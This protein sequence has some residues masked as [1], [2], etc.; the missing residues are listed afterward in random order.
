MRI[1]VATETSGWWNDGPYQAGSVW[2]AR[3]RRRVS[4]CPR[5]TLN[6]HANSSGLRKDD[7]IICRDDNRLGGFIS[8]S[9]RDFAMLLHH[10]ASSGHSAH[11]SYPPLLSN[12]HPC[13]SEDLRKVRRGADIRLRRF[14]EPYI[15]RSFH[16]A[17]GPR[18]RKDDSIIYRDYNRLGGDFHFAV[19]R[20]ACH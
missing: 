1:G 17:R 3:Y 18:L 10:A 6:S 20:N 13:E 15:G 14:M 4:F 5:Y 2:G 8:P 9:R 19:I 11:S 16:S 7:S 12:C